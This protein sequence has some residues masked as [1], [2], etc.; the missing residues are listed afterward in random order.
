VAQ[1]LNYT[2][3]LVF[4][5]LIEVG[6]SL[7]INTINNLKQGL[8][9]PVQTKLSNSDKTS[10]APAKLPG[11]HEPK[12]SVESV[13]AFLR[14]EPFLLS[15]ILFLVVAFLVLP[16][17]RLNL[18]AKYLSFAIAALGI[19]LIWGYGGMLCLGQGIFFGLG[20]YAMAMYLKLEASGQQLPDFMSWSGLEKLP[21]FWQPF[22]NPLFAMGMAIIAPMG[23][24]TILGLLLFR[25]RVQGVYFSI[26][27]QALALILVTLFIGQ[28]PITGG[29]NGITNFKTVLGFPLHDANV[30]RTLFLITSTF[31]TA[32]YLLCRRLVNSPYGRLLV[33]LREDENRVRFLGYDPVPLK[34]FAFAVSAGLAGLAG[35]LFVLQVGLISP[36][37]MGIVPS[38]EMV[39]WIAVGG[40]GT[41][42]GAILGA[43]LVSFG[44]SA[45]SEL[46]PEIWP[47]FYGLL[48]ASVVFFPSGILGF[49]RQC[50]KTLSTKLVTIKKDIRSSEI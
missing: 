40:R 41:L 18:L 39:I 13:R 14:R 9:V 12:W 50:A 23:L 7:K 45:F 43:L 27:T 10:L 19:D 17:F 32:A 11:L 49:A 34:T 4:L 48:I 47:Y 46:F 21:T 36:T 2:N 24:A 8:F 33:A 30:Q 25:S 31:L 26:V 35:A 22:H 29:T 1:A 37:A 42:V 44:K 5:R 3:S 38:A 15:L 20:A 28:Q 6:F 16:D